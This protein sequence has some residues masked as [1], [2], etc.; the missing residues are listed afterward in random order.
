M[1]S[2]GNEDHFGDV[3][4]EYRTAGVSCMEQIN[5]NLGINPLIATNK[6]IQ[7]QQNRQ[8]AMNKLEDQIVNAIDNYG[9]DEVIKL[10]DEL[11]SYLTKDMV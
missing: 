7:M 5:K 1:M 2:W 3:E 9:I 11:N 8:I 6:E 4:K 10:M